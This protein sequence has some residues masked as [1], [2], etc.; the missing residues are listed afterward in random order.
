MCCVNEPLFAV[1][2]ALN[3]PSEPVRIHSFSM[4]LRRVKRVSFDKAEVVA[5]V[6]PASEMSLDERCGLWYQNNE[7][8]NFKD[9]A[10]DLCRQIRNCDLVEEQPMLDPRLDVVLETEDQCARGLEHRISMER[11]KNKYLTG[12]AIIKAQKRYTDP[13]QLAVVASKCTAWAKEVALCTGYQDFYQAYNPALAQLV[14]QRPTTNFPLL[15]RKRSP[16]S[17]D[18]S[19]DEEVPSPKRQ[20]T[21]SPVPLHQNANI[22][23]PV[24]M[25]N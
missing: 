12:R 9:N 1:N 25:L 10:R 8:E 23:A 15:S 24:T 16:A 6:A 11:Q 22:S 14:P 17:N 4:N 18:S 21:I 3:I 7:L 19:S 2:T 13:E 20:R 5:T